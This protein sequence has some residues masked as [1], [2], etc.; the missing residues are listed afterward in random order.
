MSAK[1]KGSLISLIRSVI[2][3]SSKDAVAKQDHDIQNITEEI[4]TISGNPGGGTG[5]TVDLSNYYT[6]AQID[7]LLSNLT[8]A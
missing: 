8:T 5:G 2:Y 6:K 4:E 3:D 1:L 7:A